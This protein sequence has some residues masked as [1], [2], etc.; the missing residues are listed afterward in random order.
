MKKAIMLALSFIIS[1]STLA[2]FALS[3][4][5]HS[6]SITLHSKDLLEDGLTFVLPSDPSFDAKLADFLKGD[7]GDAVNLL[8]PFSV[9]LENKSN[10]SVVAYMIQWCFTKS[11]G[12]TNCYRK[13][14]ASPKALMEGEH[15]SEGVEARSGRIKPNSAIFLSLVSPDGS[16]AFRI[17]SISRDEAEKIR[18]GAKLDRRDLLRR[19]SLELAEYPDVTVSIDGAFFEDGTF[20]GDNTTGFFEQIKAQVDAKRDLL[21]ELA[22]ESTNPQKSREEVFRRMEAIANQQATDLNSKSTPAD[23]YNYFKGSYANEVLSARKVLGDEKGL[24]MVLRPMKKQ[25]RFLAKKQDKG[26]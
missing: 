12:T 23:Y 18:Q 5:M 17:S 13:A 6:M 21:N 2:G 24:E 1:V 10:Q 7:S 16:G 22:T 25:W 9:F 14:F 4:S 3:R 26:K 11:D 19:F 15:L 20:V 8:R